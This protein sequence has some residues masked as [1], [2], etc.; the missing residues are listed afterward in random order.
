MYDNLYCLSVGIYSMHSLIT[1]SLI[2]VQKYITQRLRRK[3]HVNIDC[4]IV[5]EI[6]VA[7][8]IVMNTQYLEN[9][10]LGY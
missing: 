10:S 2:T 8:R 1:H 9:I 7:Y 5:T 3:A 4:W 6:R